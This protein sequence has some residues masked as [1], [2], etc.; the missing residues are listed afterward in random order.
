MS[1]RPLKQLAVVGD[2]AA[3]WS[4]ALALAVRLRGHGAAIVVIGDAAETRRVDVTTPAAAAFHRRLALD[5]A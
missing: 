1:A 5:E 3:A 2:S 4:V